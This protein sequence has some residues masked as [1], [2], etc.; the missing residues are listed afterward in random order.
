MW[1]ANYCSIH[2]WLFIKLLDFVSTR[3][4]T[5]M[6]ALLLMLMVYFSGHLKVSHYTLLQFAFAYTILE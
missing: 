4:W 2:K 6:L 3:L 1:N 5:L